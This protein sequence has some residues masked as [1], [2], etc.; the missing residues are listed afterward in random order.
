[1]TMRCGYTWDEIQTV[2]KMAQE[3][4]DVVRLVNPVL[5][6]VCDTHNNLETGEICGTIWG[7]CE[8]CENC[9]SVRA[10]QT[11]RNAYKIEFADKKAF[12][13]VSRYVEIDGKPR[14]LELVAD[15]TK[16]FMAEDSQRDRIAQFINSHNDMLV[17]DPLTRLYNRRFLDEHF[18]PSLTCCHEVQL[19]VNVAILD[20]DDFKAT[21]DRYGHQAGDYLLKDVASF[22]KLHFNSRE[23]N[24]ERLVIRYGGDEMLI[25]GCGLP[26]AEFKKMISDYYKE[27]RKICYYKPDIHFDFSM[28]FGIA[29][30]EELPLETWTWEQLFDLA[31]QRLYEGKDRHK[32]VK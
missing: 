24:K 32:K 6:R 17:T 25:I 23:K 19:T 16:D 1:M 15:V 11:K 2:M 26:A 10:L 30:S 14:I 9:T 13:V 31:D 18:V 22:W 8:R 3:E 29:S 21:N 27:M 5:R 7:R 28:S 12:L 4:Y 20:L